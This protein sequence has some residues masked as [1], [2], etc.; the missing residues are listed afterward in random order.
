MREDSTFS[1]NTKIINYR[2][3]IKTFPENW[4]SKAP[5]VGTLLAHFETTA[6]KNQHLLRIEFRETV[7][8]LRKFQQIASAV[9]IFS[10][11]FGCNKINATSKIH[12]SN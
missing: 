6:E 4:D 3:V 8:R 12:S 11:G 10:E 5:F 9:P 2:V 1:F 7:N